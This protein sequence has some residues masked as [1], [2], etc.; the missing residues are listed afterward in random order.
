MD[1][2]WQGDYPLRTD[3]PLSHLLAMLHGV[4]QRMTEV[5]LRNKESFLAVRKIMHHPKPAQG[6]NE[7]CNC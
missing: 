4:S 2:L 6:M 3:M 5:Q 7:N 1:R